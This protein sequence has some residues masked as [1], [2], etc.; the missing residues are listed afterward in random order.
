VRARRA[1]RD[2]PVEFQHACR[3][4]PGG[5][6]DTCKSVR[7]NGI[8]CQGEIRQK[9]SVLGV[10]RGQ[11]P[12]PAGE[13]EQS[14]AWTAFLA[15]GSADGGDVIA[16]ALGRPQRQARRDECGQYGDRRDPRDAGRPLPPEEVVRPGAQQQGDSDMAVEHI[17]VDEN[18]PDH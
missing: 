11:D 18:G 16:P 12:V 4:I 2:D 3:N 1:D 7:R 5:K 14:V 13:I 9:T 8:L 15:Y 10:G 6:L 17:P